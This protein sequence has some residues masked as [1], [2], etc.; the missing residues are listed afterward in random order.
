[1]SVPEPALSPLA[2][3]G[4][5]DALARGIGQVMLQDNRWAGL[6]FLAGVAFNSIQIGRAHV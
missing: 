6:L 5:L 2:P 1:M 4:F 3:P